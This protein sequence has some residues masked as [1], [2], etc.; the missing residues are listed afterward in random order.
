MKPRRKEKSKIMLP[1]TM[2]ATLTVLPPE[3]VK[4]LL[5]AAFDYAAGIPPEIISP[6]VRAIW[7][8]VSREL[9]QDD[10]AYYQRSLDGQWAKY[11]EKNPTI[12]RQQWETT[13]AEDWIS[14]EE[15]IAAKTAPTVAP[16]P[17]PAPEITIRGT[18]ADELAAALQD[19]TI[20]RRLDEQQMEIMRA[21]FAR[22]EREHGAAAVV[23][24]VDAAIAS[25]AETITFPE[26]EETQ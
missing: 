23:A 5:L 6:T 7:P 16:S 11:K 25:R 24:A 26:R 10:L 15:R 4:E 17:A 18:A 13:V 12:T 9:E 8:S 19:W 21:Y 2:R 20:Y 3:D 22:W 1:L 14:L